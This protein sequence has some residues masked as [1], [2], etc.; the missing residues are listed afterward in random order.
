MI[1]LYQLFLQFIRTFKFVFRLIPH[2]KIR[3]FFQNEGQIHIVTPLNARPLWIHASSGEIE[4]AKSLI[5]ELK[6][7][8][9]QIP[10]LVTHT[11]SSSQNS[12]KN[13]DVAAYGVAPIDTSQDVQA[14]LTRW[15]PRACLIARTDL[16]PQTLIELSK[17]QIPVYLFSATFA[18]GSKKIGFL[19]RKI[20]K[21]CLPL[22]KK[23]YFVSPDDEA[24]CKKYFPNIIGEVFGDTRYD[25]VVYRLKESKTLK[26]P[27][28]E[29]ILIAGS[30]WGEDEK[31]LAPAFEYLK[32]HNWK[33]IL[34]PHEVDQAHIHKLTS[35][36]R[37]R[38]IHYALFSEGLDHFNWEKYDML[39]VDK[40]GILASLYP[41]AQI[42]FV[43]GSF[44]RQVHS[45]M[46]ALATNSP[47]VLGPYFQNN[48]EAIEFE[49]LGYVRSVMNFE[50][51][52][53][54]VQFFDK[55]LAQIKPQ[56]K[57]EFQK[58]LG[59]TNKLIQ[60]LKSQGLLEETPTT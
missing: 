5:R 50:E 2:Q 12:V 52:I 23:I 48:R 35:L 7:N 46:E 44:R 17:L 4:Y 30:T 15:N 32:K 31:I 16:W 9:S 19:S 24:L 47:V 37:R 18:G 45:V 10:L 26:V 59:V 29:K 39:L 6:K 55:N 11:S 20:L 27:T 28:S 41:F 40:V 34:V 14:F 33:F 51:F 1:F 38:N 43:G 60:D 8:Y 42:A 49:N 56:L 54:S 22:I 25:Q 13:L 53:K 36:L 21:T 3:Y 58:R 57:D